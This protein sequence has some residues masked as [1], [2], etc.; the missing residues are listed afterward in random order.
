MS[1]GCMEELRNILGLN[2]REMFDVIDS[3]GQKIPLG[4][5]Y[6]DDNN[7]ILDKDGNTIGTHVLWELLLGTYNIEREPYKP[8]EGD[9]YWTVNINGGI[10]FFYF[11]CNDET[12]LMR[13]YIMIKLNVVSKREYE[14]IIDDEKCNEENILKL[15]SEIFCDVYDYNDLAEAEIER[16]E[17][18]EDDTLKE[19]YIKIEQ[20]YDEVYV[21]NCEDG[22]I[23]EEL[24]V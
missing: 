15:Y 7:L 1:K 9:M 19:D 11:H 3:D 22:W 20:V 10:D 12:D 24:N 2:K 18:D 14:V 17:V 4:P 13:L 16:Y 8:R 5:Y 21:E 6:F 23:E